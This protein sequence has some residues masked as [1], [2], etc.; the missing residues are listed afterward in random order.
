MVPYAKVA[1][2][3]TK[4][5]LYSNTLE[6]DTLIVAC[7]FTITVNVVE[8]CVDP[9]SCATIVIVVVPAYAPAV[10]EAVIAPGFC[11]LK[12]TRDTIAVF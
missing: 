8:A 10:I 3:S 12:L 6:E 11:V 4:F 7:G 5:E 2:M 9:A 1:V